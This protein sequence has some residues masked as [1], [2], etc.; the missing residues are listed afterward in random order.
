MPDLPTRPGWYWAKLVTPTR[1]PEGED[2]ASPDWEIVEV[3]D[4][5]GE[6]DEALGVMVAGIQP[7]Q[8]PR[9][10]TW[11]PPVADRKPETPEQELAR[12]EA[13]QAAAP[14][15]GGAVAARQERIDELRRLIRHG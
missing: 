3:V 6:G 2:W 8:W 15:W 4:N 5:G 11:G 7:M 1:M 14:S 9:D 10:F 13:E 12:L